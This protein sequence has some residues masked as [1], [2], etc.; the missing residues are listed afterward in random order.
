M[1]S[2]ALPPPTGLLRPQVHRVAHGTQMHS[3]AVSVAFLVAVRIP[4]LEPS[5]ATDDSPRIFTWRVLDVPDGW[6]PRR[7][8]R[9]LPRSPWRSPRAAVARARWRSR[10]TRCPRR[11]PSRS[12]RRSRPRGPRNGLRQRPYGVTTAASSRSAPAGAT[13][14][15]TGARSRAPSTSARTPSTPARTAGGCGRTPSIPPALHRLRSA[16]RRSSASDSAALEFAVTA[17]L[18]HEPL[19]RAIARRTRNPELAERAAWA[20]TREAGRLAR[21]PEPP[22]RRAPHR[23][24]PARFRRG[25]QPGRDRHD[26][27][28]AD[29]RRQ[30]R[31]RLGGPA[32]RGRQHL[33]RRPDP[34]LYLMRSRSVTVA[35]R[36]YNGCVRGANTPRC[37]R[38]PARV[39]QTAAR[40]RRD[41]LA[42]A[43]EADRHVRM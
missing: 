2:A 16:R 33:P 25:E 36:R 7:R 35:L 40:L 20:V 29:P 18:A 5:P 8:I 21:E 12:R 43:T 41:I 42:S 3:L 15:R 17:R 24:P 30:L 28:D 37:S 11:W 13:R 14:A 4:T 27:G 1:R 22:R 9:A 34:A 26:A 10:R 38:Y 23:E 19:A 31:L 6:S 32:D 39:L